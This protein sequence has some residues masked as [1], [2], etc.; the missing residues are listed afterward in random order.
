MP[1]I[2]ASGH[3]ALR[4]LIDTIRTQ[5]RAL[6]SLNQPV[7]EHDTN[8]FGQQQARLYNAT[9]LGVVCS[10]RRSQQFTNNGFVRVL[11]A[12]MA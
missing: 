12:T 8:L 4:R 9:R 5:L 2:K 11:D 3:A 7:G 6:E 1:I 10:K